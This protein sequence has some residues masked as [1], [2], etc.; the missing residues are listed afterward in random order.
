MKT[1]VKANANPRNSFTSADNALLQFQ[2]LLQPSGS[3]DG[4]DDSSAEPAISNQLD[5]QKLEGIL[6]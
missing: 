2:Q 6:T 1:R 4:D 3:P 5:L